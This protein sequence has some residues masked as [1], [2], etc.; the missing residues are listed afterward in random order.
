MYVNFDLWK[1]P[2]GHLLGFIF[3]LRYKQVE[4]HKLGKKFKMKKNRKKSTISL[5]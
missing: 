2:F 4:I 1:S 3:L 5:L